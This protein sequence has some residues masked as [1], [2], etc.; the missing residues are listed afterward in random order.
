MLLAR[1]VRDRVTRDEAEA[2]LRLMDILTAIAGMVHGGQDG[3]SAYRA[4]RRGLEE[5]AGI[6]PA[7]VQRPTRARRK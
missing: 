3:S 4:F 1:L 5:R 7:P 2:D 6:Q